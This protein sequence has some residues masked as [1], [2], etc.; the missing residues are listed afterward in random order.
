MNSVLYNSLKGERKTTTE[1]VRAARIENKDFCKVSGAV[2]PQSSETGTC[3]N[4]CLTSKGAN[5][6]IQS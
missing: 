3:V 6:K 5:E 2:R 4:G 1:R